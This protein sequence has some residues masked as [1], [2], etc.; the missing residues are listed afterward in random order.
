MYQTMLQS[1]LIDHER[2]ALIPFTLML[3]TVVCIVDLI[4][5]TQVFDVHIAV[6]MIPYLLVLSIA[7]ALIPLI[8]GGSVRSKW[9]K[10][11]VFLAFTVSNFILEIFMLL[12][13][14]VIQSTGRVAEI[15]FLLFSPIFVNRRFYMVV[16]IVTV[17]K[18]VLLAA[19]L[20]SVKLLYPL[21]P[22]L[23]VAIV[24]M[25]VLFRFKGFM[26]ATNQSIFQQ[27]EHVVK[28]IVSMIELKDPYTRGHSE[29]VAEYAVCLAGKLKVYSEEDLKMIYQA[30]LL[31]DVGKIHVPDQILQK[32][33][34]LTEQEFDIIKQHPVCGAKAIAHI[35][36]YNLC[37]DIV[38]YHHERWDGKGYPTG[39]KGN[40]IPLTARIVAIADAFDAMTT[41]RAYRDAMTAEEAFN[42]LKKNKGSQFDP[43][44]VEYAEKHNEDWLT[45][46][47]RFHNESIYRKSPK[48]Q[49]QEVGE[50]V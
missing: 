42:E 34:R 7:P 14:P 46:L 44:L 27:L 19:I 43:A 29:R 11:I 26:S 15:Y 39:I 3:M 2:R 49:L 18:Y 17:A 20:D 30:C 40:Q 1:T 47:A 37:S 50:E 6:P 35:S 28:G 48:G 33:G 9:I 38:M 22:L 36:G 4:F 16:L 31:H 25:V 21:G 10:Y 45:L 5:I 24:A 13:Q 12:D 32:P 41:E 8:R 23:I